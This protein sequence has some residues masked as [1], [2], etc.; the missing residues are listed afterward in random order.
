MYHGLPVV[1][2]GRLCVITTDQFQS[3]FISHSASACWLREDAYRIHLGLRHWHLLLSPWG[4][5][6]RCQYVLL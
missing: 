2:F 6:Q 4:V 3:F 5:Q 1:S